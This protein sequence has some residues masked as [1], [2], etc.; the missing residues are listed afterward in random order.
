MLHQFWCVD[1]NCERGCHGLQV[2]CHLTQK[3]YPLCCAAEAQ[4]F[5]IFSPHKHAC[6]LTVPQ[7]SKGYPHCASAAAL[8]Q[9]RCQSHSHSPSP[10]LLLNFP[11]KLGHSYHYAWSPM[12]WLALAQLN[13][14]PTIC[15]LTNLGLP[16]K[17]VNGT[18]SLCVSG[19]EIP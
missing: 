10:P 14:Q 5:L 9:H 13:W 12:E 8:T 3:S 7:V 19:V 17:M 11:K 6:L 1:S 18:D 16:P 2:N 15:L 4:S